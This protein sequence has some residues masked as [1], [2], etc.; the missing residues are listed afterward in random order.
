MYYKGVSNKG[1]SWNC[2]AG[3][4]VEDSANSTYAHLFYKKIF[5]FYTC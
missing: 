3:L 2:N 5:Y 4:T 1:N